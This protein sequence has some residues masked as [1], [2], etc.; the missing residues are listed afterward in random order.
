MSTVLIVKVVKKVIALL[1]FARLA[2]VPVIAQQQVQDEDSPK[3]IAYWRWD[4]LTRRERKFFGMFGR[5][6][7]KI[8]QKGLKKGRYGYAEKLSQRVLNKT[9]KF[10]AESGTDQS[11]WK[12]Y[13]HYTTA[14][15]RSMQGDTEGAVRAFLELNESGFANYDITSIDLDNPHLDPIRE[16][17][18]IAESMERLRR[19]YDYNYMLSISTYTPGSAPDALPRFTYMSPDD[20]RLQRVRDH[21]NLDSIA[22]RGDERSRILNLLCWASDVVPH[23]GRSDNPESKNAVDMVELCRRQGR[24]V[25][26]R[27]KAQIFNECLLAMGFKSRYIT[28]MPRIYIND[29][30]VINCVWSDEA[31]KWLWVDPSF[32]AYITD[33]EGNMLSITEVRDRIAKGQPVKLNED[34]NHN[35][36]P[37]TQGYYLDYYMTK[38]LYYFTCNVHSRADAETK[39]KDKEVY[40]YVGLIPEGYVPDHPAGLTTTDDAYFWQKPE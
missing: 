4:E 40:P 11:A 35:G 39:F 15:A 29:C 17:L 19:E 2:A 37:M 26:C 14:C 33:N 18:R 36:Q 21:F 30:H 5:E 12:P 16:D 10:E 32:N 3:E 13:Y 34:A 31:G 9:G 23:D 27:M 22:G 24:G 28:C 20:F 8:N 38:N 6:N 25:N 7:Y 1:L